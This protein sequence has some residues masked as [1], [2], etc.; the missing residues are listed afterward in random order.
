MPTEILADT[1]D[2]FVLREENLGQ[3]EDELFGPSFFIMLRNFPLNAHVLRP[4]HIETL[5]DRVTFELKKPVMLGEFYAM[6][7]RSGTRQVNYTVAGR[8][9]KAVQSALQPFGA[10]FA[11]FNHP[12]CKAIGEDFWEEKHERDP[13]NQVFNDNLKASEFRM[14]AIALTPAPIG[15]PTRNFQNRTVA[16][17]LIF[18][19]RHVQKRG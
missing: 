11:K 14:V 9:L 18:C 16:N 15:V 4:S 5:R 12:L 19:R 6:T 2:L 1:T 8:R 17:T 7:D 10:P 13:N 3:L